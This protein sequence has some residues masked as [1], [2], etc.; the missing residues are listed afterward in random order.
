MT[1]TRQAIKLTDQGA[2]ILLDAAIEHAHNMGVPQCIAIVDEGCNLVAFFRMTGS[3]VLSIQSAQRKA[4]TAASTGK[5]TGGLDPSI[6]LKLALATNGDMVNIKGG[7]PIVVDGQVIGGIGVG[8]GTGEQDLEV[9]NAALAR[10]MSAQR[11]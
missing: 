3:R 2:R 10:F 7:A 5:P 1:T 8:S 4:M 11:S 9:A 6:D